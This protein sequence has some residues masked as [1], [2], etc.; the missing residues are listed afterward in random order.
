MSRLLEWEL[1][2]VMGV[3]DYDCD[4]LIKEEFYESDNNNCIRI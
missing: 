1:P 2:I 3:N 4:W